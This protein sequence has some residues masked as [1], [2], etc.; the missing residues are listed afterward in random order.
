MPLVVPHRDGCGSHQT[1]PLRD[2]FGTRHVS[3]GTQLRRLQGFGIDPKL[4][5]VPRLLV[6][7]NCVHVVDKDVAQRLP[8]RGQR[9]ES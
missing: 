6:D 2:G 5:V 4:L 8:Q 3:V 7:Q 1:L 9:H